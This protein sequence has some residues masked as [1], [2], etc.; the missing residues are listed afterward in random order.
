MSAIALTWAWRQMPALKSTPAKLVLV[1]LAD[2]ADDDGEL[3]PKLAWVAEKVQMDR[4][5]VRKHIATLEELG[6]LERTER[7][8]TDGDGRQTSNLLRLALEREGETALPPRAGSSAPPRAES[9][10]QETTTKETTKKNTRERD[11]RAAEVHAFYSERRGVQ[12]ALTDGTEK[13]MVRAFNAGFTAGDLKLAIV[14]LL[15]SDWHRE[16]GQ[17]GLSVIFK[18]GPGTE[19][20]EDRIQ[21]FIDRGMARSGHQPQNGNVTVPDWV[22]RQLR[23]YGERGHENPQV[24]AMGEDAMAWLERVGLEPVWSRS[25]PPFEFVRLEKGETHDAA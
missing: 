17:L 14:G 18:T 13:L 10:Y 20:F 24:K 25:E 23:L 16:R 1:A 19:S 4:R 21:G 5:N 2:R 8:R 7:M 3:Y 12:R 6:L 9:P 11:A 15:G 22:F